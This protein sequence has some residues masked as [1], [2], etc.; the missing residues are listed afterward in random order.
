MPLATAKQKARL[1]CFVL[2]LI[3]VV[4]VL[5]SVNVKSLSFDAGAS[6]LQVV[7]RWEQPVLTI[8]SDGA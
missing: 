2:L 5:V 1:K 8:H 6:E 3:V 4:A 7:T